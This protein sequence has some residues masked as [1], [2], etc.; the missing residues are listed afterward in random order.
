[1]RTGCSDRADRLRPHGPAKLG[2]NLSLRPKSKIALVRI[3][4]PP[5]GGEGAQPCTS[6]NAASKSGN[7]SSRSGSSSAKVRAP[8][9]RAG[10]ASGLLE[11]SGNRLAS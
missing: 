9:E 2:C 8:G 5:E 3:H 11:T 10:R 4:T 1:M 6:V 7:A